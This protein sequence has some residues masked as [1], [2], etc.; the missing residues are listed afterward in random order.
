MDAEGRG[1]EPGNEVEPE[2][3]RH[4]GPGGKACRFTPNSLRPLDTTVNEP[5]STATTASDFTSAST[6][7]VF[8]VSIL[9][10]G[11]W[12]GLDR[13]KGSILGQPLLRSGRPGCDRSA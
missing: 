4:D 9:V 8:V 2:H 6:F 12:T 1:R 13:I 7:D 11:H 5:K 10:D 3:E